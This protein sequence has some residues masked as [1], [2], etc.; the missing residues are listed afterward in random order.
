MTMYAIVKKVVIP[1]IA[2]VRSGGFSGTVLIRTQ[3]CGNS[4]SA[5]ES[6]LPG[7]ELGRPLALGIRFLIL[8]LFPRPKTKANGPRFY[9][10]GPLLMFSRQGVPQLSAC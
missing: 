7:C 3:Y 6:M 1:A 4:W 8:G 10:L 9:N 2:S 5:R